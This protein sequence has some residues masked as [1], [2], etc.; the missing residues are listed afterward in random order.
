M[1]AKLLPKLGRAV[2]PH[3]TRGIQGIARTL[4]QNPRATQ[5]I[6]TVPAITRQTAAQI[7]RQVA[8]GQRVTPQAAVRTLARQANTTLSNPTRLVQAYQRSRANDRRYHATHPAAA[9]RG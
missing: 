1:A 6:R 9:G 5:L 8:S 4:A 2:A 7:A 3:L